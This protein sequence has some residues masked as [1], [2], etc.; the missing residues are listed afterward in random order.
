MTGYIAQKIN[1]IKQQIPQNVKL[2]AITKQG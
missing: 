2:I 1:S